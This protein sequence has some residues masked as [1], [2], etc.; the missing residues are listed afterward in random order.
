[1]SANKKK[2]K[3]AKKKEELVVP[4]DLT[5]ENFKKDEIHC[6]MKWRTVAKIMEPEIPVF[7]TFPKDLP[8]ASFGCAIY[9]AL[10]KEKGMN[11]VWRLG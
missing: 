3:V 11:V 2:E 7:M 9:N 6:I 4:R 8:S 10:A 5:I 1:M